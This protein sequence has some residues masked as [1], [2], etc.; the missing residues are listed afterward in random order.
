MPL[1]DTL[2]PMRVMDWIA[3]KDL[4][5][6]ALRRA[7]RAAIVAPICLAITIEIVGDP[8]M[9]TFSVF[10][11]LGLLILVDLTI[12]VVSASSTIWRSP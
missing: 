10:A 3:A 5:Y 1:A 8:A 4:D 9:A 12:T 2:T 11:A 7:V 6:L